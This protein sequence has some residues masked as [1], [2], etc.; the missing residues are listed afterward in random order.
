LTKKFNSARKTCTDNFFKSATISAF[1][2]P[3]VCCSPSISDPT[4]L[5]TFLS[6]V[7]VPLSNTAAV[8]GGGGEGSGGE[9]SGGKG[10]GGKG[11]GGEG[12]GGK[13][14]GGKGLVVELAALTAGFS[15]AEI[16]GVV[17]AAA[18]HATARFL[19]R[20]LRGALSRVVPQSHP[21]L[22]LSQ[23]ISF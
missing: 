6:I 5:L 14:S 2:V 21:P 18:S 10:S 8:R 13:G 11:S 19:E 15:G 1:P 12:S 22:A 7:A 16:A 23:S 3:K 17:R 9:G 4:L 20:S